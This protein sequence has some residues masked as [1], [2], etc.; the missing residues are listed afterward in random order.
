METGTEAATERLRTLDPA[1]CL[2]LL[3]PGGVGRV[4]FAA[5]EGIVIVPVNFALAGKCVVV[6]TAP[7][8]LL[9]VYSHGQVSFQVDHVDEELREGWSVLVH[10]HAHPVTDERDIRRLEVRTRLTPWA[11]GARDV[12]VRITPSQI[13]GRGI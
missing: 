12:F 13:S 1:E 7:D 10:G 6:R 5:A 4:G 11:G 2:R 3:E 8:T 9:A